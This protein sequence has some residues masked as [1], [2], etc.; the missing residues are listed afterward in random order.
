GARQAS[1]PAS[2][3]AHIESFDGAGK[4]TRACRFRGVLDDQLDPITAVPG[5]AS[6]MTGDV[7]LRPFRLA[8]QPGERRIADAEG[9]SLEARAVCRGK[10]EADVLIID[11]ADT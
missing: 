5:V 6:E 4:L 9:G 11:D 3:G 1:K 10:R 7:Q 2:L 8:Q